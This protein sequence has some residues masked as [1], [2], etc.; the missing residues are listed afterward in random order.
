M[1]ETGVT[2]KLVSSVKTRWYTEH[3]SAIHL[4]QA[5]TLLNRLANEDWEE[6][7]NIQPKAKTERALTL[8]KSPLFW[9]RLD[10]LIEDIQLASVCIGELTQ[11]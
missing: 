11:K 10:E 1:K 5:K 6:L 9:E 4:R 2:H 8:M 7:G 3:T